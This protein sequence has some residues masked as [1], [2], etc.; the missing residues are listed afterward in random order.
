MSNFARSFLGKHEG[1]FLRG[2]QAGG[3]FAEQNPESHLGA[4]TE[5]TDETC[6][7]RTEA[8]RFDVVPSFEF[9]YY[10]ILS[11][12]KFPLSSHNIFL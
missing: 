2:K 4:P 12:L 8:R 7:T 9:I 11:E 3:R 1:P 5:G 6:C 10:C